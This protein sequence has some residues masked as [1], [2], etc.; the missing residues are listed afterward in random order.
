YLRAL[1]VQAVTRNN[2]RRLFSVLFSYAVARRYALRNPIAQIEV[3]TI[4]RTKPAILTVPEC[5]ALMASLEP[6]LTP[7][8]AIAL[9]AGLR[10]EAEI[11][12]RDHPLDWRHVDLEERTIDVDRS[13]N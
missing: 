11:I 3:V 1:P 6:E 8:V 2:F 13:K 5:A 10:P 7:A 9:F 12:A 4:E